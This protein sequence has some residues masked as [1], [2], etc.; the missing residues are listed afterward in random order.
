MSSCSRVVV[1]IHMRS[2][3]N[4]TEPI[5][6]LCITTIHSSQ[7]QTEKSVLLFQLENLFRRLLHGF[8]TFI[9]FFV[10]YLLHVCVSVVKLINWLLL[11]NYGLAWCIIIISGLVWSGLPCVCIYYS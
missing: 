2:L 4:G 10:L 5:G 9:I 7:I 6:W 11:W 1:N 8:A 3:T